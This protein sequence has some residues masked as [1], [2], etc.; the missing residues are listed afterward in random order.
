[1][2]LRRSLNHQDHDAE[3]RNEECGEW[4]QEV[5]YYQGKKQ[6]KDH[7]WLVKVG[8]VMKQKKEEV[9][10]CCPNINQMRQFQDLKASRNT[11]Q[12]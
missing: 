6:Q 5:A 11:D 8:V 1:M 4:Y 9:I 7:T 12:G 2:S 10:R 3:L